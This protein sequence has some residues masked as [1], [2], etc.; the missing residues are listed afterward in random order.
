MSMVP[1]GRLFLKM[2]GQG[3][4]IPDIRDAVGVKSETYVTDRLAAVRRVTHTR[5][6]LLALRH[7]LEQGYITLDPADLRR[8]PAASVFDER[9]LRILG[10]IVAQDM[11][12]VMIGRKEKLASGGLSKVLTKLYGKVKVRGQG[13]TQRF[14]LVY[15]TSTLV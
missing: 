7:C 14:E 10:Y 8:V 6:N 11:A 3:L 9:E 4:T 13:T 2:M 5:T 15:L 1:E 12:N